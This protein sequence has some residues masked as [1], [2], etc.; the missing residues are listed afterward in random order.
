MQVSSEHPNLQ[1]KLERQ[2]HGIPRNEDERDELTEAFNPFNPVNV[3]ARA[4]AEVRPNVTVE[5]QQRPNGA[6]AC[7]RPI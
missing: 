6:A 4:A 3:A 1:A 2:M 5:N 7:S